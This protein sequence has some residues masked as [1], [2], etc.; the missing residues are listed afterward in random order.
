MADPKEKKYMFD[1]AYGLFCPHCSEEQTELRVDIGISAMA[2]RMA[3]L[4]VKSRKL[5]KKVKCQKCGKPF[6]F[7]YQTEVTFNSRA[8]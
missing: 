5:L 4:E 1:H 8:L 3:E 2:N 6:I 7:T